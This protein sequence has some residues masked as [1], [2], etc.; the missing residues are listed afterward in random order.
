MLASKAESCNWLAIL[1]Q[2]PSRRRPMITPWVSATRRSA[3]RS[4]LRSRFA[5]T[6]SPRSSALPA[7]CPLPVSHLR[8]EGLVKGAV[9]PCLRSSG[10]N[11]R[12]RIVP[13]LPLAL[14][15]GRIFRTLRDD[16]AAAEVTFPLRISGLHG[17]RGRA[18]DR[19]TA[20]SGSGTVPERSRCAHRSRSVRRG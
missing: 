4:V 15:N 16:L 6:S 11:F 8:G 9:K 7:S 12:Q 10:K 2:D 5:E 20:T 14:D 19:S 1:G 3:D 17:P 18:M 13:D